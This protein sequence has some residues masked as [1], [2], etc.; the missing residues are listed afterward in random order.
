MTVA[1]AQL[2]G[3]DLSTAVSKLKKAIDKT[4]KCAGWRNLYEGY[5]YTGFKGYRR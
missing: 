1:G 5:S 4:I 3:V 2:T